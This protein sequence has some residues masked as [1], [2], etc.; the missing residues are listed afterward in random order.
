M[1]HRPTAQACLGL[2]VLS[3]TFG[4]AA[5]PPAPDPLGFPS[6]LPPAL[7]RPAY[8]PAEPLP[9][10][11]PTVIRLVNENSPTIGL[12]QARVREAVARLDRANVQWL[13]TLTYG[14]TYNRFDGQTQNQRGEV[15]GV[16]RANFYAS[17]GPVLRIDT[18]DAY[19][20]RLVARRATAAEFSAA[21]Y[22]TLTAQQDAVLAYLDLVEVYGRLAVNADTLARAEQVRTFARNARDAQLSK[23]AADVNRAETEVYNRRQE[24]TDLVGRAGVASARLARLLLLQPSVELR[25][26]DATV[27]PVELVDG[28]C[29]IDDLVGIA[30]AARPDLAAYRDLA[31]AAAERVRKAKAGPLLPRVVLD[32]QTGGFGGGTNAYVGN[33]SARSQLSVGV[34]WELNNLGLG[35]AALTRESRAGYDQ[36][37][38]RLTEAQARAGAE[39]VEAAKLAASRY[40]QLDEARKAVTEAA[41]T[42]RK[43]AATSFNMVGPRAQYDALEPLIA[44]QQLNQARLQYLTV[45]IEFNRAQFRLHTALGQPVMPMAPASRALPTPKP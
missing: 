36:A 10:D 3:A 20:D 25:P 9:I 11:L 8:A 40:D 12:A 39:V 34:F 44:I 1:P 43:L 21:S 30:V 35:D 22:S 29:S 42:Y 31:A 16:S 13:P 23:T 4:V 15:F 14:A 24:R 2:L 38:L 26:A 45:V 32:Q 6:V 27:V 5:D 37:V 17:G 28:S 41:E 33:F 18:A 19:F 7:P